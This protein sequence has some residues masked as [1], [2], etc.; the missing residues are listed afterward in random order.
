LVMTKKHGPTLSAPSRGSLKRTPADVSFA[1]K[2]LPPAGTEQDALVTSTDVEQALGQTIRSALDFDNWE[3]GGG[4]EGLKKA[5]QYLAKTIVEQRPLLRDVRKHVLSRL[6]SLPDAPDA[7]GVYR[8]KEDDLRIARRSVLLPGKL[9]AVRGASVGHESLV[10]SLVSI[11]I[12][13]T[14][15][16]GQMRSWRTIFLR[17]DCD[18]RSGNPIEDILAILDRKARRSRIGPDAS[19]PDSISRLMRRALQSAAERKALLE[20]AASGWRMGYGVPTPYDLL[21][22]SGSMELIDSALPVLETLFLT[23]K[24]WVFIPDSLSSLAF[25]YIAAALEPGELAIIQKAKSTLDAIVEKGH[26]ESGY[27]TKVQSF[28]NRAGEEIVIGGFR[29]TMFSPPQLFFAHAENALQAGLIA[30]ADAALQPHRGF[31]L[32]LELAGMSAKVGLG[33]EAFKGMVESTYACAGASG[34]YSDDRVIL[35]QPNE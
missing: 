1:T 3:E 26:Y 23:E 31:P 27:K 19:G 17:H 33:I 14:R 6:R 28:V 10:A 20:K 2:P 4:L 25:T 7:A 8:V 18:V 35:A 16:D 5:Q 15:Y 34:S 21:T 9:T 12:C 32:L 24:R 30:M 22:G 11:G 13:L 29:A